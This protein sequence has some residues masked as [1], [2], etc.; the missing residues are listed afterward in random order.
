[1]ST[2]VPFA[3]TLQMMIA[4]MSVSAS[5]VGLAAASLPSKTFTALACGTPLVALAPTD[6]AL[7]ALVQ[8]H[9][10]GVVVPPGPTA[11]AELAAT[12]ISLARDPDRRRQLAAAATASPAKEATRSGLVRLLRT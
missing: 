2:R 8:Q 10:C 7:A 5:T 4:S 11:G 12:I 9:G 1:M 6:S 3:S